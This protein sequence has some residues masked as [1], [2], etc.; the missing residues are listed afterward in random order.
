MAKINNLPNLLT[1]Y[2]LAIIAPLLLCLRP[3]AVPEIGLLAFILFV[4][5]ALT[6]LA[7]GYLARKFQAESDLGKLIDPLADKVLVTA[8]LVMLIPLGRV[9]A[10][11]CFLILA[12]EM[13]VT[14]LRS[15]AAASGTV[16]A[17]SKL[18]KYKSATQVTA[19]A[20]LIFPASFSPFPGLHRIGLI[21]LYL[22]LF[23]TLWSGIHYFHRFRKVY[24]TSRQRGI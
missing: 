12:R 10:W 9:P 1:G 2:R 24:L 14:G 5:A 8:G 6:D 11:L 3:G 18:G 20:I 15:I 16:I 19:L 7:D 21:I 4:S 13:I 22:A 23:L 17:A